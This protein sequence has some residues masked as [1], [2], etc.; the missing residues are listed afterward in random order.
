MHPIVY[1]FLGIIAFCSLVQAVFFA[2]LA[3]G[4]WKAKGQVEALAARSETG[5]AH[6]SSKLEEITAKL[7]VLSKKAQEMVT[8]TEPT[9][10]S[11]ADRA[12]HLADRIRHAADLPSVPLKNGMALVHG[13]LR[14]IEAYKYIRPRPSTR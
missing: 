1:V 7:E 4:A 3:F 9:V 8:R 2:G 14:A 6:V 12:E 5:L 11:A 10:S 13:V